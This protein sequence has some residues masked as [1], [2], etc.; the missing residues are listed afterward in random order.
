MDNVL[1]KLQ[2]LNVCTLLTTGRTGSD[3]LQSLLDSHI[4]I[5]TFNGNFDYYEFWDNSSCVKSKNFELED[6]IYEFIGKHIDKFKSRYDYL[7]KKDK[8]GENQDQN[9]NI[10][11]HQFSTYFLDIMNSQEISSKNCLL[12]I[13][14]AY[15][16]VLNQDINSLKLFF[17]HIHH[18][19]RLERFL[20]DFP[21]S[22]IISMTRDP[23][24]NIVSGV[25]NHKKYNSE[26]MS[27]AHQL[28]Y[29]K[30]ILLDSSV[31]AKYNNIY[32]S[33][34][35]EDLGDKMTLQ[36]I[37]EWLEVDY[38]DSMQISTWGGLVWNGDR[39]STNKRT[40]N[41]FSRSMLNNNWQNILSWRDKYVLNFLMNK[42]LIYYQYDFQKLSLFSYFSVPLFCLLPMSFEKETLSFDSFIKNIK[43][44]NF[45]ILVTNY[46]YYFKRIILFLSFYLSTIRGDSCKYFFLK[47]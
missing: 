6:F 35:L 12:A 44:N 31:L 36:K 28:F 40:G 30:R 4:Q 41:G 27:L 46:Y 5:I 39:I 14:G 20:S 25:Y 37:S 10:D 21:K 26:S 29:L 15:A 19:D 17:H 43:T 2:S 22:K 16:L 24:A 34:R 47:K 32:I 1:D 18:H 3:F 7:E 9:L 33:I 8:L 13:Y 11:I 42:R 23:R 45:K 38:F